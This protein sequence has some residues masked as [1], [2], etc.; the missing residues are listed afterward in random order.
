MPARFAPS[1]DEFVARHPGITSVDALMVDLNGVLRGKRMPIQA[2]GKL[3]SGDLCFP[4]GATLLDTLGRAADSLPWGV[5]DG[6]PDRPVSAVATSLS[7]DPVRP[8]TDA[9]VLIY[10][11]ERDGAAWFACPRTV[12]QRQIDAL[13][14]L[15]ITATIALELE[16]HVFDAAIER[17][18]QPATGSASSRQFVGPQTY[19]LLQ[20]DDHRAMVDAIQSAAAASG[21]PTTSVL[22]EYGSGQFEINLK[23]VADPMLAC[24]HAV[25]MRRA[26][27]AV[28]AEHGALATF[29]AKPLETDSGNGM[30]VHVSLHRRDGSAV[31]EGN[32]DAPGEHMRHAIAGMIQTLPPSMAMLAPNANSWRRFRADFY[33]PVSANW[34]INHRQVALRIPMSSVENLRI[35]HRVAGADA[36]PYLVVAAVLAG[37]LSGLE[38][39][40]EPPPATGDGEAVRAGQS[41]PLRWRE[42][43]S[44]LRAS[45]AF[46]ERIGRDFA[47]AYCAMKWVEE[48]Q[49]HAQVG[50]NDLCHYVRTI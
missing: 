44:A 8:D 15:G 12:L 2:L 24:D 35:E 40:S 5:L 29:M 30:H 41:L 1:L 6:D 38:S 47:G 36:N 49:F 33:A 37:V 27:K 31:F 34:G 43:L 28:A 16:F 9:Q 10:P 4:R 3:D 45:D 22:S 25:L 48:E 42:A 17:G 46:C 23:H 18:L 11:V 39:A 32:P 13:S 14:A 19:N 21:I 7:P 20:L 50:Q 26:V